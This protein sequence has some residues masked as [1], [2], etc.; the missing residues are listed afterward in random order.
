MSSKP[1]QQLSMLKNRIDAYV[2]K[3][4]DPQTSAQGK[5]F[6]KSRL[7]DEYRE[8]KDLL[9]SLHA[10]AESEVPDTVQYEVYDRHTGQKVGGPY[11]TTSIARR[12]RDKK[13]LE[14]GA[15][16][17]GVR[18]ASNK[19]SISEAVHK[20]P[21]TDA[22]FIVLKELM[23]QPIPAA[24]APIY[25]QE[26]ISD[27]ELTDQ[28]LS[29]EDSSPSM[30]VRPIIAEWFDRV[31]PDQKYR[32]IGSTYNDRRIRAGALSPLHGY[33]PEN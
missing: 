29:L 9:P 13:D 8:M 23:D 26:I 1:V 33:T 18:P 12:I 22:D 32:L 21:I 3:I 16:R 31:M 27:D 10:V 24:V 5:E 14:Y 30:D 6:L 11:K 7:R 17:Y 15:V 25:I 28:L 19:N 2:D 20:L 4:L